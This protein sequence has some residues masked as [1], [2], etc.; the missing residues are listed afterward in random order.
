MHTD[1]TDFLN[2]VTDIREYKRAMAMQM[3]HEGIATD[4]IVN[5]LQV[6][7]PFLS[8]WKRM[9]KEEGVAGLKLRYRGSKGYLT[10]EQRDQAIQWIR[11]QQTWSVPDLRTYLKDTFG[12]EYQSMQSYYTLF[13]DAGLSWKKAQATNQKKNDAVVARRRSEL[14]T[15]FTDHWDEI[16][17]KERV[18]LFADECFV[19]WGDACG[20]VWGKRDER[21]TLPITNH[22]ARQPYYGAI[23]VLT[24]AVHLVPYDRADSLSTTDFLQD[25]RIRYPNTRITVIWDNASHHKSTTVRAYLSQINAGMPEDEWP[26]TCLWFAPHDP[27]Q[28]PIEDI[29]NRAKSFV[30]Q[31]WN[32]LTSFLDVTTMFEQFLTD[33]SFSFPKLYRYCPDLQII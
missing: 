17:N 10:G 11:D 4:I 30:R 9:V 5:V 14:M 12:V 19:V 28:N 15:Y 20:Y 23:D 18:V 13:H 6:S 2:E 25:L 32:H 16:V 26:I 33:R 7:K 21:I 31:Q 29:W 8:K 24:G 1:L 3:L 27:S 22:R